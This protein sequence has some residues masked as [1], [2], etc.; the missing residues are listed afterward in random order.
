MKFYMKQK[1]LSFVDKFKIYDE[2]E[3]EAYWVEGE[4]FSIGKKLDIFDKDNNHKAH[5]HQ[6]V[7]SFLPRFFIKINGEDVAEVVKHI[8]LFKQKFTVT[9]YDWDVEGDFLAHEYEI[10]HGDYTIATISKEWF[11]WGDAY[12][13]DIADGVD[14]VPIISVVLI[15][16]A[17]LAQNNAKVSFVIGS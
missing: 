3:N 12:S 7:L 10:Y 1:A 4:L 14:P 15:I 17:I 16:D 9:G 6:K 5:I 11:T 8:T 13:V 2:R